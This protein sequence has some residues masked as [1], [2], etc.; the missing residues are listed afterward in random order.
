[1]TIE[2]T[3]ASFNIRTLQTVF[4]TIAC[5]PDSYS[6]KSLHEAYQVS[7]VDGSWDEDLG[8]R[9]EGTKE[10]GQYSLYSILKIVEVEDEDE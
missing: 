10:D 5:A 8:C 4:M 2:Y 9:I 6:D 3:L 1:M 7:D